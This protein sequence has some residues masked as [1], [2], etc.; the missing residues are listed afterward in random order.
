VDHVE[1]G[2]RRERGEE[3]LLEGQAR[4]ARAQAQGDD[5]HP[6]RDIGDALAVLAIDEQGVVVAIRAPGERSDEAQHRDV[7]ARRFGEERRE[8]DP[9]S[10]ALGVAIGAARGTRAAAPVSRVR[11]PDR[12]AAIDRPHLHP[13]PL[14]RDRNAAPCA[15]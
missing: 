5:P 10:H 9:D 7:D 1:P 6:V 13:L 8:V 11:S 2:G 3:Q 15:T 4:R 14:P 12:A